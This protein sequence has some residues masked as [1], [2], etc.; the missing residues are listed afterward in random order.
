MASKKKIEKIYIVVPATGTLIYKTLL[1]AQV[2]AK[3]E[4]S[5]GGQDMQIFEVVRAWYVQ[6]PEEPEPEV[7]EDVLGD[8]LE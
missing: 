1:D 6:I 4:C 2:S 8:L 5:I 7:N 3:D